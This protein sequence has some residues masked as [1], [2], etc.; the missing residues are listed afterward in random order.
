M[1]GIKKEAIERLYSMWADSRNG[2]IT[3]SQQALSKFGIVIQS[4]KSQLI[5]DDEIDKIFLI[6]IEC[7][8]ISE[9][10]GFLGGFESA[11]DL[12]VGKTIIG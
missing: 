9:R 7:S 2:L 5:A 10:E 4:L 8:A 6:V 11:T 1:N 3:E 12:I